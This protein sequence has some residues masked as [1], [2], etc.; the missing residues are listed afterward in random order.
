VR[1]QSLE[2]PP[3]IGEVVL[4]GLS[5]ENLYRREVS[6]RLD[7]QTEIRTWLNEHGCKRVEYTI[8]HDWD[9]DKTRISFYTTGKTLRENL[10]II[11]L[12]GGTYFWSIT[13]LGNSSSCD[14]SIKL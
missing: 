8:G 6:N 7:E 12:N 4:L 9:D 11:A 2:A 3:A 13:S 14:I 1:V 5:I 10:D